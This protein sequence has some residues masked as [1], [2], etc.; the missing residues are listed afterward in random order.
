MLGESG[1]NVLAFGSSA[2]TLARSSTATKLVLFSSA[3]AIN[4][5]ILHSGAKAGDNGDSRKQGL[6]DP[7]VHVVLGR[8]Q[9][10]V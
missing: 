1:W 8:D 2:S 9:Q 7:C 4:A 3:R 5:R 6:W 10:P